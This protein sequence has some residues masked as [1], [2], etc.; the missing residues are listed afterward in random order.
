MRSRRSRQHASR[1]P[2]RPRRQRPRGPRVPGQDAR[3]VEHLHA[4][5]V[6]EGVAPARGGGVVEPHLQVAGEALASASGQ[7]AASGAAVIAAIPTVNRYSRVRQ[8]W[9]VAGSRAIAATSRPAG[10]N[11]LPRNATPIPRPVKKPA[12]LGL[13][14]GQ[15]EPVE[16]HGDAREPRQVGGHLVGADE[17]PEAADEEQHAQAHGAVAHQL[18]ARERQEAERAG[19]EE[20]RGEPRRVVQRAARRRRPWRRSRPPT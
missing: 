13:A 1:A 8:K 11:P 16:A 18:E 10:R 14:R 9:L 3:E 19:H 7:I 2:Q 20:A 15:R 12:Q 6:R 5:V 17:Q 4:V